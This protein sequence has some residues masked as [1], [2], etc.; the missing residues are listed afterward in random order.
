MKRHFG[1]LAKLSVA[2]CLALTAWTASWSIDVASHF[3]RFAIERDLS[4]S[5][6]RL[7]TL[8]REDLILR[9]DELFASTS[10]TEAAPRLPTIELE[11]KSSDFRSLDAHLPD[12]GQHWIDARLRCDEADWGFEDGSVELRYR[13]DTYIHWGG[14]KKSFRIQ[15]P[16]GRLLDG[17]RKFNLVVPKG[18][19]ALCNHMTAWL[20]SRMGLLA[21]KTALVRV[22]CNGEDL[23]IYILTE[24]PDET[25]LR[26]QRRTPGPIYSGETWF[27]D[28]WSGVVQ[29]LFAHSGLWSQMEKRDTEP[30]DRRKPLDVLL[31]CLAGLRDEARTRRLIELID[32]D[33]FA[34]LAFL[35]EL[36]QSTH[37]D[38][39][40]NWRLAWNESTRRFEPIVWDL[41]GWHEQW[42]PSTKR[43]RGRFVHAAWTPLHDALLSS[44]AFHRSRAKVARSFFDEGLD[45]VFLDELGRLAPI[46]D[47]ESRSDTSR[48]D[49]THSHAIAARESW[50]AFATESIRAARQTWIDAPREALTN[51]V[52]ACSMTYAAST[53]D[54]SIRLLVDSDVA[55]DGVSI[56]YSDPVR[57]DSV[58]LILTRD[59]VSTE[60]D[61]GEQWSCDGD[62]VQ[63]DFPFVSAMERR[64]GF[65]GVDPVRNREVT[66]RPTTYSLRI[67]G[68][69]SQQIIEVAAHQGEER[70]PIAA[71][72]TIP[73][74]DF[75]D[76]W[77]GF[78]PR[79]R[80]ARAPR[81]TGTRSITGH[82]VLKDRIAIAAGTKLVFTR[83]A[84]LTFEQGVHAHGTEDAPIRFEGSGTGVVVVRG[85]HDA[86]FEHC[87]FEGLGGSTDALG[88]LQA[89]LCLFGTNAVV[90][91]C[92][93]TS[94][95]AVEDVIHV[96]HANVE[97][98][99]VLV[100][101]G[102]DGI[103]CDVSRVRFHD[104]HVHA[105]D[106]DGIDLMD[107][108]AFVSKCVIE[109]CADKAVSVGERSRTLVSESMLT[110]SD[111]GIEVKDGSLA[112]VQHTN[113]SNCRT[114]VR[115]S[116][117][118]W[119]YEQG[120]RAEC[121]RSVL[122]ARDTIV[123]CALRST[124]QVL[125]C[126]VPPGTV[127]RSP[128]LSGV[129]WTASDNSAT[130]R[131]SRHDGAATPMPELQGL[132]RKNEAVVH[133]HRGPRGR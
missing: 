70:A 91:H 98:D 84:S 122:E 81:W 79:S 115:A 23:G 42:R 88:T 22:G 25:L 68:V 51:S 32:V 29:T 6:L 73:E 16:K 41:V 58:Q 128:A 30:D 67:V 105:C 63:I 66:K 126:R 118:N 111:I 74:R 13:G 71:L 26:S 60:Y 124:V 1:F 17:M 87:T 4:L 15:T 19:D 54:E 21:P 40:H 101:G 80:P 92:E 72:A 110:D 43:R 55:F 75:G 89:S 113:I 121:V 34:R 12:S 46:L 38:A 103:D 24:Q 47:R 117:K 93:F 116:E 82:V 132:V 52:H 114:G 56:R 5:S 10:R 33:A 108:Q 37:L 107:S 57:V 64:F 129:E 48:V 61:L 65:D 8:A 131:S 85:V 97:F 125:D 102:I 31:E 86:A 14:R 94:P 62:R 59:G 20:A 96:A 45:R 100:T 120:G 50:L 39:H 69:G 36:T 77:L 18:G 99:H 2:P 112:R 76:L 123:E 95:R 104:V 78:S 133:E 27:R 90:E 3:R 7:G 83:G 53:G 130:A 49:L 119:R 127:E 109:R 106:G 11:A 44:I 9:F 35:E 28:T